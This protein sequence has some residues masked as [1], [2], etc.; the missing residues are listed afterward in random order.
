VA[1]VIGGSL[2][3][4]PEILERSGCVLSFSKM[5]FPD[6]MMRVIVLE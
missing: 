3:L 5:A 2:E 6:Q 1:F 4:A